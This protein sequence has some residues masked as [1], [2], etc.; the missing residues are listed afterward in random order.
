[1]AEYGGQFYFPDPGIL[2]GRPVNHFSRIVDPASNSYISQRI[3][4]GQ[5]IMTPLT[6]AGAVL[7]QSYGYHYL[8]LGLGNESEFNLDVEGMSWSPFNALIYDDTFSRFSLG[9]AH[10]ER[11]PDE[12]ID[13]QSGYPAYHTSGL[14]FNANFDKNVLGWEEG[15][16]E[17]IVFDTTLLLSQ[18]SVYTATSGSA[19]YPWP[20]S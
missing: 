8:G 13:P 4:F 7:M 14:K 12:Y 18:N 2:Y 1:M 11:F 20:D 9:L 16:V 3:A 10:S 17:T 5:G 6:P 19:M 15:Y